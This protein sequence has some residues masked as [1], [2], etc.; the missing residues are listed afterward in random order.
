MQKCIGLDHAKWDILHGF[1]EMLLAGLGFGIKGAVGSTYN[2]AAKLY[3]KI[4]EEYRLGNISGAREI[5][6]Q[7]V[8]LVDVL[9][10]HGGALAAGKCIMKFRGIDCGQC[11][12][13]LPQIDATTETAL[14]KE[15]DL[16]PFNLF[17]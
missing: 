5:Q 14:L 7:S 4:M 12:L 11:R 3:L 1:D 16:L 6:Q 10:R 8:K 13:P 2:Y 9:L 17:S 15:L